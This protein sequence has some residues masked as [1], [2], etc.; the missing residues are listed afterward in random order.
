M[1]DLRQCRDVEYFRQRVRGRFDEHQFGVWA[2]RGAKAVIRSLVDKA[3]LDA[4]ARQDGTEQLLGGAKDAARSHDMLAGL[5][6]GHHR[7]QDRRHA[8]GGGDASLGAFQGSQAILQRSHRRIGE[9]GVDV[10]GFGTGEPRR[11][12]GGTAED[13][14]RCQV[15]CFGMLVELAALLAG[16][17]GERVEA[18]RRVLVDHPACTRF[19]SSCSPSA[20]SKP[21]PSSPAPAPGLATLRRFSMCCR[22]RA[23]T[24]PVM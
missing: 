11:S 1:R 18:P 15:E 21:S 10:A 22:Y 9:A 14:A 8:A 13:K 12:L 6:Q 19:R 5:H 23:V 20:P 3:G 4:E 17:H 7:G 16:A 24:S 2:H